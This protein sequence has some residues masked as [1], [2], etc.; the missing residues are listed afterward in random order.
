M[1]RGCDIMRAWS[2]VLFILAIHATLAMFT[3]TDITDAGLNISLDTSTKGTIIPIHNSTVIIPVSNQYFNVNGSQD[4]I[5]NQ[6]NL[7]TQQDFVSGAIESIV[8]TA[9]T[10]YNLINTF[11]GLVFSIHEMAAPF[12]G[13]FNA[14]VL[15]GVVDLIMGIALFQMVTGRSFKTME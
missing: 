8:G 1:D 2:I 6:S 11:K 14:W 9:T 12:F 10:F 3:Y 7:V 13:D 15:E 4:T 5:T